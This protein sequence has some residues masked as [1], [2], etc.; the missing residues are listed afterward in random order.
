[1]YGKPKMI[2]RKLFQNLTP[3]SSPNERGAYSTALSFLSNQVACYYCC[4]SPLLC[5]GEFILSLA[6]EDISAA[7]NINFFKTP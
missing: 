7:Y 3:G 1:M 6:K 4:F 2:V 5:R